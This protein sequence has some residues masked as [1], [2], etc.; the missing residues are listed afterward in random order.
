MDLRLTEEE[1]AFR[2]EV[3]AFLRDNLP[4]S[5]REKGIAGRKLAKDDY[6]RWTRILADKGWAVPFWPKQW[7]GTGWSPVKQSIFL[8]ETQRGNAPEAIAF[9]VS[10]VGPV[11]YTFGSQAQKER[12]LP[13]IVDLRDWWCQGFSEPGAGSDLASLRT[14]ARR[15]GD[16]W[17]ISGQKT[18]TTMAQYA[19]WIFVLARTNPQAKKQ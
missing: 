9:G 11:I 19:D 10:M 12:F 16:S 1:L 7:G 13:R 6:V 8:D 2:A 15:D 3:R 18:W 14:S 17:V 4:A 5:I